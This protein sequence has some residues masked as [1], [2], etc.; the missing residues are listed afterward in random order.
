MITFMTFLMGVSLV[1]PTFLEG[2]YLSYKLNNFT[3][4]TGSTVF[5]FITKIDTDFGNAN[6][7]IKVMHGCSSLNQIIISI[8]TIIIFFI[9]CKIDSKKNQ[10][11][12][13]LFA[14]LSAFFINGL[15]IALL[16]YLVSKNYNESFDFWHLGAGSLIFSFVIMTCTCSFYYYIWTKENT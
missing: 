15:R 10:I 9:C 14:I 4:Y 2:T 3:A 8:F 13:I 6:F 16:A 11:M 5:S 1:L 12:V 7:M